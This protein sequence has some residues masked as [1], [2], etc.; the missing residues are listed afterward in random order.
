MV[1]EALYW[2]KGHGPY[3]ADVKVD[4]SR[5]ASVTEWS[6]MPGARDMAP[7]ADLLPEDKGPAPD[8]IADG[9]FSGEEAYETGGMLFP[10]VAPDFR[11]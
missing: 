3:Y 7:G 6:E 1:P 5:L 10:D 11:D 4:P 2:L 9:G 8:Q